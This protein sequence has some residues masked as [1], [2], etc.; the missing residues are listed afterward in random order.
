MLWESKIKILLWAGGIA[1]PLFVVQI[2]FFA[3]MQTDYSHVHDSVSQLGATTSNHYQLMNLFGFVGTG[4]LVTFGGLG[5]FIAANELQINTLFSFLIIIFGLMFAG[6][7]I[8]L[9]VNFSLH[10]FFA[11]N[12]LIPLY[13]V[14]IL[15]LPSVWRW[16][17]SMY[18]NVLFY[19]LVVILFFVQLEVIAEP[20]G[21]MQRV[22]ILLVFLIFSNIFYSL[23]NWLNKH[24]KQIN[25]DK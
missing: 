18:Q 9:D 25:L 10:A 16:G 12:V 1:L 5:S 4:V 11:H 15:L 2:I 19:F 13:L 22:K 20:V 17:S 23:I 6:I 8:P 7:A 21:V 14:I 3:T 24:S